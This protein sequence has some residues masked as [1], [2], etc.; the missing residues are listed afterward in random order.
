MTN[1]RDMEELRNRILD[2]LSTPLPKDLFSIVYCWSKN[3]QRGQLGTRPNNDEV[4]QTPPRTDF[5][6]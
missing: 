4:N 5:G 6:Q 2:Q 1:E 3:W